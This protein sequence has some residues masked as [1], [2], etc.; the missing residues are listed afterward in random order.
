MSTPYDAEY[1]R[2]GFGPFPYER[3]DYWLTI[4]GGVADRIVQVLHPASVFDAGCACGLLVEALCDRGVAAQGRDISEHAIA[5]VRDDMR[6]RCVM[7]SLTDPVGGGP[8]DLITCFE[9][10]E[11]MPEDHA[12]CVIAHFAAATNAVL[13]SSAPGE[14]I[15]PTHINVHPVS[16]WLRAFA[17]HGFYP[18]VTFDASF[19]APH[20]FLVRRQEVPI[21][22]GL[23]ELFAENLNLQVQRE[24]RQVRLQELENENARLKLTIKNLESQPGRPLGLRLRSQASTY[25]ERLILLRYRAWLHRNMQRDSWVKKYWE[26]GAIW[27]ASRLRRAPQAARSSV[28]LQT[29]AESPR[30]ASLD[31]GYET[32]VRTVEPDRAELELQQRMS[33][34]FSFQPLISVLTPVY[35]IPLPILRKALQSVEAQTYQR[36]EVCLTVTREEAA[37][38]LEFLEKKSAEDPRFRLIVLPS[39]QGISGNLNQAL[40]LARGEYAA[41]LDHDDVLAPFAFFEVVALLNQERA[42]LV[43]SDEDK[44]DEEGTRRSAPL[45]KPAWS[46]EIM[47]SVNYL[48]HLAVLRTSVVRECGGWQSEMD[49]AQDWDLFLRVIARSG[50]VRH[51][52]K[53]LYHWRHGSTSVAG[54]GLAAKPH[55]A[56]AQ[57][58]AVEAHL[59]TLMAGAGVIRTEQGLRIQWP[60]SGEQRVSVIYVSASPDGVPEAARLANQ[61]SYPD[62]EIVCASPQ[63]PYGLRN[64]RVFQPPP[65]ANLRERLEAAAA[66]ATGAVL[67]FIDESVS[68]VQPDWLAEIAGPLAIPGVGMAGAKLI[69]AE[70]GMLRHSGLVIASGGRIESMYAGQPE[71]AGGAAGAAAAWYRNCTAVSGACFAIRRE[72]WQAAGG[73]DGELPHPRL[74][75]ALSLKV[76]ALASWRI[77]YNPF[78]RLRQSREALLESALP[79]PASSAPETLT[80]Y[81][82][83]GDPY[84]NPNLDCRE[85]NVVFQAHRQPKGPRPSVSHS[86][87]EALVDIWTAEA[88]AQPSA[89]PESAPR[90][91]ETI[92]WLLQAPPV[93][94]TILR[95]A[96]R[97]QRDHGVKSHFCRVGRTPPSVLQ[98]EVASA[99]PDLAAQSGFFAVRDL[100]AVTNLPVADAA[101]CSSFLT[102]YALRHFQQPCPKFYFFGEDEALLYPA[103]SL[104]ALAEAACQL[105]YYGICRSSSL[106]NT[107]QVRGGQGAYFTPSIDPALFH[108]NAR[109]PSKTSSTVFVD[110][111]PG[112]PRYCFELLC[113]ALRIVKQR[114]GERMVAVAAGAH[115][116]PSDYGLKGVVQNLGPVGEQSRA[117]LFRTCDAGVILRVAPQPS[118]LPLELMACGAVVV[119]NRDGD[120]L[121]KDRENC[122]LSS[123]NPRDLADRIEEACEDASLRAR[124]AACA[125]QLVNSEHSRW[126]EEIEKIYRYMLSVI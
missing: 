33:V 93:P 94:R 20:A 27:L 125:S 23:I 90:R 117:A 116:V 2:V 26:P 4:F 19:I 70:S 84:F 56:A 48:A 12:R 52:P 10:L 39:N 115:W 6:S 28:G 67:V 82:P 16:Y 51:I 63:K 85:G 61:T 57:V 54:L 74:D 88:P 110:A 42:D 31:D 73:F 92:L 97:F 71:H 1:Y 75:V 109:C 76:R 121:L 72:V 62:F 98:P 80:R 58:R 22:P 49:G 3:N 87:V 45:Y 53:V 59:K 66:A 106:W 32:W 18:D 14:F 103:S 65:G 60:A 13:F 102:A 24:N 69:D 105:G 91:M 99:F 112:D 108:S 9:V 68:P 41:L 96:D 21:S 119:A 43:Y 37:E 46:P 123:L 114:M 83:D 15:E 55:A 95:F 17:E 35:K 11:H 124:L 29:R 113:A 38:T 79:E 104:R 111:Q 50:S 78:A 5:N 120:G 77:V 34:C 122:L 36:W 7:G 8:F 64:V 118:S 89:R 30:Q 126:E 100:H 101:V 25:A 81:L 107:Y 44:I 40:A 86:E 47:L